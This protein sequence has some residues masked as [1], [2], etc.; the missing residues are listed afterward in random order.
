[1]RSMLP[2]ITVAMLGARRH[3]AVPRLLHEAGLL[4]RFYTDS[5]LGNKPW[6]KM[7]LETMPS[8]V[9][10]NAVQ[11]WLGR[12]DS[13]L[14][15]EKVWS[16]ERFGLWYAWALSRVQT[17]SQRE[18]ICLNA[19][20]R[21]NHHIL[22]TGL[23]DT[24]MIWGFNGAVLELFQAAKK[25][26]ILCVMEQTILPKHL[27]TQLLREET[28][29]WPGW[30]PGLII[31]EM[32]SPMSMREEQEWAMA[33]CIV[34]GSEFV[35]SGLIKCGVPEEKVCVVPYG[36]DTSRFQPMA[37]GV[38]IASNRPLRILFAGHVGLR[39]GIPDLLQALQQFKPGEVEVQIAGGIA[40][41]PKRLKQAGNNVQF[42]GRVPRTQMQQL[43]HWADVF[44]LPSIVEG[45]ATATYESLMSG[46]PVIATPNAG[47]IVQDGVNGF[48]VPIRNPDALADAIARYINDRLLLARHQAAT[49]KSR[50]CAGLGRYRADLK[51]LVCELALS[52]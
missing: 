36:V 43:F 3:Y 48:I 49:E 2:R 23:A 6:L 41:D 20:K 28:E 9:R 44:V 1:M 16:F 52:T 4:K 5:Y 45:S 35:Q 18:A 13:V 47:S 39:K 51:Q 7:A 25:Q 12:C 14:P 42:L 40:L 33:D 34:A 8:A 22:A 24:N 21:F 31:P 11:R 32:D 19:A 15:P 38:P 10:P 29:R 26:N 46:V 37:Q 27:E 17:S 50:E 30:E